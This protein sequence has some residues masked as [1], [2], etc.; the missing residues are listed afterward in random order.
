MTETPNRILNRKTSSEIAPFFTAA[1]VVT[2][3]RGA[4][5]KAHSSIPCALCFVLCA[6]CLPGL[7]VSPAPPRRVR[8]FVIHN[9]F[10]RLLFSVFDSRLG[11][12]S[13]LAPHPTRFT[14]AFAAQVDMHTRSPA[15][16]EAQPSVLNSSSQTFTPYSLTLIHS[17]TPS[18]PPS[19]SPSPSLCLSLPLYLSDRLLASSVP[20]PLA[21]PRPGKAIITMSTANTMPV[22]I[23]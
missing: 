17:P 5:S 18:P 10:F 21:S 3:R 4:R 16:H 22:N 19:P 1:A 12:N 14:Q 15:K 20:Q 23:A 2:P 13:R 9:D 8:A 7:A 6:L 11:G